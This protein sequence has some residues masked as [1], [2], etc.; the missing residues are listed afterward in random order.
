MFLAVA[1]PQRICCAFLGTASQ[2]LSSSAGFTPSFLRQCQWV[3]VD[4]KIMGVNE[5]NEFISPRPSSSL[6]SSLPAP[7][8]QESSLADSTLPESDEL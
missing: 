3:V 6:S 8:K 4:V 7:S 5:A 2:L 1:C